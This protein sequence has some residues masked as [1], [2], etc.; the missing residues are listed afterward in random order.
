MNELSED[1]KKE[2][3]IETQEDYDNIISSNNNKKHNDHKQ[4]K[5]QP[6]LSKTKSKALLRKVQSLA[7]K[8]IKKNNKQNILSKLEKFTA[9]KDKLNSLSS[10]KDIG[11]KEKVI[12]EEKKDNLEIDS[13]IKETMENELSDSDSLSNSSRD[14]NLFND[15]N[16]K[17]EHNIILPEEL[18]ILLSKEILQTY[19]LKQE[20]QLLQA[21]HEAKGSD[22]LKPDPESRILVNRI[23]EIQECRTKLPVINS[24]QDIVDMINNNLI[25]IISGETG[26]GKSTQIP[27]FLYEYGYSSK[28]IIGITQPRRVAAFALSKR[29]SEELNLKEGNEVGYQVRNDNKTTKNTKIKFMT[30]GILL[31]EIESD[32]LLTRYSVIF[33]D[34]AHERT[35]NTDILIGM[36]TRII[37]IRHALAIHK[38]KYHISNE[39]DKVIFPLRLVIMSATIAIEDFENNSIFSSVCLPK[40]FKIE[41]RQFEVKVYQTK[42]T[43][44]NYIDEAFKTICR[45]HSKL[46][47]G[48]I[49]CFLTG[50]REISNM[51]KRLE[52]EFKSHIRTNSQSNI[53][54]DESNTE[55]TNI[56][57]KEANFHEKEILD[58]E[59]ID[60]TIDFNNDEKDNDLSENDDEN[61]ENKVNTNESASNKFVSDELNLQYD[62]N[63]IILPLYSS[64][65]IEE[66]Q[67]V[68]ANIENKRLI[69]IA[70]NVAET[71]ITIPS[72]RYVVDCGREKSRKFELAYSSF[73]TQFISQASANQRKGR[74]G[75]TGPGYCYRLYSNGLLGKMSPYNEPQILISPLDQTLL[76]LKS[77]NIDCLDTF[78]FLTRPNKDKTIKALYHLRNIQALEYCK[79]AYNEELL[80]KISENNES[81]NTKDEFEITSL[82]RLLINF[83]L[84]PRISKVLVVGNKLGLF[85]YGAIVSAVLSMNDKLFDDESNEVN[86]KLN[87]LD[88]LDSKYVIKHSDILTI[89]NIFIEIIINMKSIKLNKDK[90]SY[91][92]TEKILL[93]KINFFKLNRKVCIET[94]DLIILLYQDSHKYIKINNDTIA[95]HKLNNNH[96]MESAYLS[97]INIENSILKDI[98]LLS[99]IPKELYSILIQSILSGYVDNVA[100]RTEVEKTKVYENSENSEISLLHISTV[101]IKEKPEIIIYKEIIKEEEGKTYLV[102]NS[103]ISKDWLYSI[104]GNHLVK[105][106]SNKETIENNPIYNSSED[107]IKR[108]INFQYGKK[109]WAINNVLVDL[110]P[111]TDFDEYPYVWFGKFLLDGVI[112][113][114]L[115]QFS[116]YLNSKSTILTNKVCILP[117][118][119]KLINLLKAN[120][121]YNKSSL[122]EKLK[123]RKDFLLQILLE[124][125]DD[126]KVKLKYAQSWIELTKSIK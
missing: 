121:I 39:E 98:S 60:V 91:N 30:D 101:L 104:G 16:D 123:Q 120:K 73:K 90:L 119:L 110:D 122:I 116:T 59:K 25:T 31:K 35:L 6:Q 72:I 54:I 14:E 117:K 32:P 71:S 111:R 100:K 12:R 79:N 85:Y 87:L 65:P 9:D 125:F 82:G 38:I 49:L 2:M 70:T 43:S 76:Y 22:L 96:K 115:R 10:I 8:K 106:N 7:E 58:E 34:E 74:A 55:I 40:I 52:S 64:L 75:R 44:F 68:F 97:N 92:K 107:K 19:K 105:Y 26:S 63:Y 51:V 69:I 24:E 62:Q 20:Y 27:Q 36:L 77:L 33:I 42:R 84:L 109:N 78:P 21:E 45:I 114:N 80:N 48:G 83:P 67:R 37:K 118:V 93:D 5:K 29:V 56:L 53:T 13:D 15:E 57:D 11:K 3:G 113:Q 50:K 86:K 94:L 95:K 112:F 41:T 99:L 102:G 66:Q 88:K 1:L 124:W 18:K 17:I 4:F 108:M 126:D 47:I 103:F 61:D 23:E 28:G 46:P 89:S 81:L